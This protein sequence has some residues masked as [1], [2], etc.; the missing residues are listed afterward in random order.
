MLVTLFGTMV[1]YFMNSFLSFHF[2]KV[3]LNCYSSCCSLALTLFS[4]FLILVCW[5]FFISL[6]CF[7]NLIPCIFLFSFFVCLFLNHSGFSP[8]S[9]MNLLHVKNFYFP[10]SLVLT[11]NFFF[12]TNTFWSSVSSF[13]S[14]LI[15]LFIHMICLLAA[16]VVECS[17][18]ILI[19]CVQ[20]LLACFYCL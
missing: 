10:C 6:Q 15:L 18:V 12:I 1:N 19:S 2:R 14:F 7:F 17:F 20:I 11:L 13:L 8:V 4:T 9:H 3:Y 5:M 16:L